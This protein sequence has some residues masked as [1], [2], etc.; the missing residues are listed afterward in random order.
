MYFKNIK[1]TQIKRAP[2]VE[3]SFFVIFWNC[4]SHCWRAPV[5]VFLLKNKHIW[6]CV[7]GANDFLKHLV[8]FHLSL[9]GR[10]FSLVFLKKKH[11]SRWGGSDYNKQPSWVC[12]CEQRAGLC[13]CPAT[14]WEMDE[15]TTRQQR[16]HQRRWTLSTTWVIPHWMP[17]TSREG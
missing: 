1:N 17:H 11:A 7:Y 8:I 6:V 14:E 12:C 2:T 16:S 9:L 15:R 13:A 4:S 5:F 3:N 10:V